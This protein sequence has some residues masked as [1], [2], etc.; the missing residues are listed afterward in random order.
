MAILGESFKPYVRN[1]IDVRQDKLS[2]NQNRNDDIL[3]YI[4]SKTSFLR[5]TSGVD[6]SEKVA[7]SLGATGLSGNLLAK[8]YVLFSSRFN[9]N[10]LVSKDPDIWG[11]DLTSDIGYKG[12]ST[13][14][15]FASDP[16]YGLVPPPGLTTAT[17]N[18]LNR[19]TI[20]EATINLVC[21]NLYQFKAINALFLKLKYSLLLEW[22]HTLYFNNNSEL[23]SPTEAGALNLSNDF[24]QGMSSD[25]I[26]DEIEKKRKESNGNYDAFFGVVKNFNWELQEN[27]SYNIMVNAISQGDVIESLKVNSNL[28]PEVVTTTS[29]NDVDETMY[30]KSTLH[31]ILGWIIR[32]LKDSNELN[33]YKETAD[34]NALNTDTLASITGLTPG[35]KESDDTGEIGK[36]TSSLTYREGTTI[37]FPELGKTYDQN[38]KESIL[39]QYYIKLGTL[40]RIIE[41]FLLYYDTSKN[42]NGSSPSIFYIN[43][44]FDDGENECITTPRHLSTDPLTCVIPLDFANAADA[45]TGASVTYFY[46]QTSSTKVFFPNYRIV[47]TNADG[48]STAVASVA[49]YV[50]NDVQGD[51]QTLNDNVIDDNLIQQLNKEII[52][53]IT[54]VSGNSL[55]EYGFYIGREISSFRSYLSALKDQGPLVLPQ[56]EIRVSY[57][58]I[59]RRE[60]AV[61]SNITQAGVLQNIDDSFRSSSKYIGN[62]MHIFVNINKIIEV[63]DSNIDGNGNVTIYNFLTQL[64]GEI[65]R[66]MGSINKFDL[67]Y[68][69]STNRFSVIDTAVFPLKYQ[70]LAKDRIAKFNINLLKDSNSGGGSFITNFGLKSDVFG[71]ISNAIAVGSQGNGNNLGSNSTPI[72]SFNEGII[73]RIIKDKKNPNTL[74]SPSGSW[75]EQNPQTYNKYENFKRLLANGTVKTFEIDLYR[76]TLVDLFNYDLGYY[77][78]NKQIPG[79]GFIPLNLQLTMDGLSGMRQ[80]QTFDIDETL[81]PNEYNDRL[82]FITTT[83]T[84]K[85]DTKGWETTISSLG[86]PKTNDTPKPVDQNIPKTEAKTEAKKTVD[87]TSPP[88]S[89]D[90]TYANQLRAVLNGLSYKEKVNVG[91]PTGEIDSAGKDITKEIYEVGS[92]VFQ[93]IKTNYPSIPVRVT[94]GRDL[95]H[96]NRPGSPHNPGKA[97]D[98]TVGV[99]N[100]VVNSQVNPNSYTTEER[101]VLDDIVNLLKELKKTTPNLTYIDEY[102]YPSAGSSGGHFHIKVS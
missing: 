74:P 36:V 19:G 71:Q 46:S 48:S 25:K 33:G 51:T 7:Q 49:E 8:Q 67:D 45:S 72:S 56:Q 69:E 100:R 38:G 87:I 64:L 59:T 97:L 31:Y 20:R 93:N 73:D 101:K 1:Q 90:E 75:I 52:N 95:F 81:L 18:T 85:I 14:Y 21:H 26:L 91:S 11:G 29:I 41:A 32:K 63:L 43:H 76:N 9:N 88:P 60:E 37:L 62:T 39:P 16:N 24:L 13:S 66:A 102:R 22:G 94:A 70:D 57:T 99:T 35:Y 2:L 98:F 86:V 53:S 4:T 28:A 44:S 58:V 10:T 5:L 68:D 47:S 15:G 42:K 61:V 50:A 12:Y 6:I 55:S 78:E 27:G 89:S 65:S 34:S 23:V 3:K 40:L 82:K 80:Y 83:I 54:D 92:K 77:T 96:L 30:K 79:T 84:H 17:I